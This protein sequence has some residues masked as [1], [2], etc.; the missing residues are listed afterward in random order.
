MTRISP[1]ESAVIG[2]LISNCVGAQVWAV[3]VVTACAYA[4]A[5]AIQSIVGPSFEEQFERWALA[6]EHD[7]SNVRSDRHKKDLQ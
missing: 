5:W 4:V 3:A 6:V 1:A 7:H 2:A